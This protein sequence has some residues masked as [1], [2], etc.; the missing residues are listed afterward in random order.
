MAIDK[1]KIFIPSLH[2]SI[3]NNETT[4]IRKDYKGPWKSR[5]AED[6]STRHPRRVTKYK[7]GSMSTKA[8]VFD[9]DFSKSSETYGDLFFT[10][11]VSELY[12]GHNFIPKSCVSSEDFAEFSLDFLA[13]VLDVSLLPH[14]THWHVSSIEI[15]I[16]IIDTQSNNDE[17][18][19]YVAKHNAPYKKP[20]TFFVAK[21]SVYQRGK[22]WKRSKSQFILYDKV[23][24]QSDRKGID[25]RKELFLSPREGCLRLESRLSGDP[26]KNIMDKSSKE[27][28]GGETLCNLD[29]VFHENFQ[30]NVMRKAVCDLHLNKIITTRKNL[31]K[32]IKSTKTLTD[33]TKNQAV[34]ILNHI[35]GERHIHKIHEQTIK[36]YKKIILALGYGIFT[37]DR[38]I[39]PINIK[40]IQDA[41]TCDFKYI[42]F[43]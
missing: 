22:A 34:R 20:D 11:S 6:L 38:E 29:V 42:D 43:Q 25:L 1:I 4:W 23:K 26:L 2:E 21:G 40:K 10:C 3:L 30:Y 35:S 19:K 32:I 24:E 14:Y 18:L 28:D 7:F 8:G 9:V 5:S 12:F 13:K 27:I 41:V 37:S 17:R 15:N 33:Y 16:D 39:Q 36:K 31:V